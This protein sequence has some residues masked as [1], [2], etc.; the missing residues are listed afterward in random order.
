LEKLDAWSGRG[1][2]SCDLQVRAEN[3]VQVFL[4]GPE[5]LALARSA[6][7]E[8]VA[9]KM[10]TDF[11]IRDSNRSM[12]DTEEEVIG[13]FLPTRIAFARRKINYFE[14][15]LIRVAKIECFDSSGGG[16]RCR[17]RS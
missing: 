16:E 13:L 14:V 9:I 8:Q 10:Q 3:L 15:M 11:R 4:L 17:Q 12:M 5:I 1:P 7:P 2:H 6:K